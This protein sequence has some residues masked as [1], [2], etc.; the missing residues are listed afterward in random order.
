MSESTIHKTCNYH[1]TNLP[2]FLKETQH[3]NH[4]TVSLH[5]HLPEVT[6]GALHGGL[7]NNECIFLLVAL[8]TQLL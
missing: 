8:K 7:S 5:N 1:V 3:H 4:S 2:I 6:T